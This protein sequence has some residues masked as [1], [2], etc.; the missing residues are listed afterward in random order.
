MTGTQNHFAVEA[1]KVVRR[2]TDGNIPIVWGGAHPSSVPEQTLQSEFVDAVSVGE[3]DI[4][5]L[6]MV[7]AFAGKESLSRVKGIAFRDG[8]QTIV[9]P[10]RPLLDVEGKKDTMV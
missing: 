5:F 2:L 1:A 3:G 4:T 7:E 10:L 8:S 9:T 6:E